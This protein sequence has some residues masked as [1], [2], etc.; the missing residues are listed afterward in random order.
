MI[1]RQEVQKDYS[2][3]YDL[4][5]KSFATAAYCAGDEHDYLNEIRTKQSFIPELS[6]VAEL[7][8][9][10]LVGQVVLYKMKIETKEKTITELLLS[11]LSVHPNHFRKGIA[12]ALVEESINRAK[13]LGYSAVFLCGNPNFYKKLKFSATYK[14]G[15][16]HVNDRERSAE[17]CMVR[18]I[19][20]GFL[21][22]I[23]GLVDII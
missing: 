12:K 21:E 6:L 15:I 19:K 4:V 17:W 22:N 18:E 11:P 3:I 1:I 23:N 16:Y 5:K 13:N 8:S 14:F 10:E 7:E 2:K 9:G 20:Q